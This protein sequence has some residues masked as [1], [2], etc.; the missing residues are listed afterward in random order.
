MAVKSQQKN[1][2]ELTLIL[3]PSLNENDLK[4]QINQI[5][6]AIKSFGGDILSV[7]EPFLRRFTHKIKTNSDG[8]YMT[9]QF[10][11]LPEL[12]NTLKK[13]L[14]IMDQLLRYVLI[15]KETKK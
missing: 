13:S 9:I 10:N 4:K 12:P 5:E 3:S 2:Y 6:S 11:S 1:L 7:S 14:S 15:S 8:Y